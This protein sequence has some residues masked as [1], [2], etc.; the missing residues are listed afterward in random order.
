MQEPG[1]QEQELQEQVEDPQPDMLMM[2]WCV[3]KDSKIVCVVDC[4]LKLLFE[5]VSLLLVE[6]KIEGGV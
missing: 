6:R 2:L 5:E 4:C 1:A 3:S